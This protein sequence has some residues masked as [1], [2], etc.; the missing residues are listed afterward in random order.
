MNGW[1]NG[2][3]AVC[4]MSE[5]YRRP[6]HNRVRALLLSLNTSLLDTCACYFG[7]G[8]RSVL[9]LGEYRESED[10]DFLCADRVGYRELRE[11]VVADG[12]N[13]LCTKPVEVRREVRMDMYGIRAVI[14]VDAQPLKFEIIRE[15]RLQQLTADSTTCNGVRQ[16]SRESAFAEKFLANADRGLDAS[17]LGRDVIDLAHMIVHWESSEARAGLVLAESV[18]GADVQGKLDLTVERM[19]ADKTWRQ[20]CERS[21]SVEQPKVLRAGLEKLQAAQWRK[22]PR[23]RKK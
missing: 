4:S 10:V 8:T 13:G 3:A 23:S 7:G 11:A 14:D 2:T 16:L 18:Y 15:A 5:T 19:Q 20:H 1:R 9:A 17:T 21:L 12:V 6:A 22:A